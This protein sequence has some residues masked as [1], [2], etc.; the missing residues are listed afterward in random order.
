MPY[1]AARLDDPREMA[2]VCQKDNRQ[3]WILSTIEEQGKG[4]I[5]IIELFDRNKF[6]ILLGIF[7]PVVRLTV[8]PELYG[9][10]LGV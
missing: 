1:N 10:T 8:K 7:L 2:A 9:L 6:E 3:L 4:A 5:Y